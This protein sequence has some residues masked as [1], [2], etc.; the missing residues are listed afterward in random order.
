MAFLIPGFRA[1]ENIMKAPSH[2]SIVQSVLEKTKVREVQ[3][4]LADFDRVVQGR[5]E[6]VMV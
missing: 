1:V 4:L 2:L 3:M 5:P 6:L